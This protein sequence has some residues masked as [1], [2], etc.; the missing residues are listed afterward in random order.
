MKE[1]LKKRF[2]NLHPEVIC[3]PWGMEYK[4]GDQQREDAAFCGL[5]HQESMEASICGEHNR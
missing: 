1:D 2:Q 3:I 5:R 4:D